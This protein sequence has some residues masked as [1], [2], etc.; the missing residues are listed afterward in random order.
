[1]NITRSNK[2]F[3]VRRQGMSISSAGTWYVEQGANYVLVADVPR[4]ARESCNYEM[5]HQKTSK[6]IASVV[7][8]ARQR[9]TT[10]S[11]AT[12]TAV[13]KLYCQTRV[14]WS[15][16]GKARMDQTAMMRV[17]KLWIYVSARGRHALP[18]SSRLKIGFTKRINNSRVVKAGQRIV[19]SFC[20]CYY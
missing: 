11:E 18:L 5:R 12:P 9:P 14:M 20:F 3:W 17:H 16:V 4:S 19:C 6:S 7:L 13:Y 1:M 2:S 10:T 8:R 15:V